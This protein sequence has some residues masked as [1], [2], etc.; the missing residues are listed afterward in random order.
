MLP[1]PGR[2]WRAGTSEH[3]SLISWAP[4]LCPSV[5]RMGAQ[6]GLSLPPPGPHPEW[7]AQAHVRPGGCRADRAPHSSAPSCWSLPEAA[8]GTGSPVQVEGR[9]LCVVPLVVGEIKK[10]RGCLLLSRLPGHKRTEQR[11]SV[12][13]SPGTRG[14]VV[15]TS[16]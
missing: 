13:K 4:R 5:C 6:P 1:R 16:S 11:L 15:R 12:R 14:H 2:L 8:A 9:D 3:T 7:E 10:V